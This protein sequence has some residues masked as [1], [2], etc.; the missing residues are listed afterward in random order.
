MEKKQK[1]LVCLYVFSSLI[2]KNN[3]SVTKIKHLLPSVIPAK[4]GIHAE[5]V[6]GWTVLFWLHS[7]QI[8]K[9]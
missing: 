4:A 6:L 7:N 9:I 5:R 2:V 8:Y 3:M 1:E